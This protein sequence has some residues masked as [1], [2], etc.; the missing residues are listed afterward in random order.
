MDIQSL[1]TV[2]QFV[3]DPHWDNWWVIIYFFIGGI[4]SGAYFTAAMAQL[5]G[6][7]HHRG[8]I[9][10]AH[11][12]AFPLVLVCAI[13][14]TVDLGRPERFWH[15]VLQSKTLW[16]M[17]KWWSPMSIGAVALLIFGAFTFASFLNAL[18]ERGVR[19]PFGNFMNALHRGPIGTVYNFV[20]SAV[21]FFIAS[22]TGVLLNTTNQ[23]F[24]ADQTVLGALFLA[25]A[26]ST[27]VAA[28]LLLT[29][30]TAE[31]RLAMAELEGL[32][33]WV[34]ILEI[35]VL[36]IFF[37][38][39]GALAVPLLVSPFG[40]LILIGVLGLGLIAPL[41]LLRMGHTSRAATLVA[42]VLVLLGGFVL[43]YAVV[44][45]SANVG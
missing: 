29:P 11:L 32:D 34:S 31:N 26:A 23:P 33:R 42:P 40:W 39:L 17:F 43:R 6:A 30:R 2:G 13:L 18:Y 25:S 37:I 14:L 19:L 20:G 3:L 9:N 28:T 45:M 7:D 16:P 8:I 24:W 10:I 44:M 35:V 36:V 22:Y 38:T 15:M 5:F 27:G 1:P 41:F 12:L 21:G 4:A